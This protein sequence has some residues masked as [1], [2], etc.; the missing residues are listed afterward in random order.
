MTTQTS[1]QTTPYLPKQRNFPNQS[2]QALGVELDKAYIDIANR[3]NERTIG[4]FGEGYQI[5]TGENFFLNGQPR[6]QQTLRQV[7]PFTYNGTNPF[8]IPHGI[9]FANVSSF[10]RIWG[11]HLDGTSWFNL[12]YVDIDPAVG[13]KQIKIEVDPTNIIITLGTAATMTRGLMFLEWLSL[14]DTNS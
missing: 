5:V 14:V 12:P 6:R 11:T 9:N 7:Y 2:S 13:T 3:V 10:V 8:L 4:L 1:L